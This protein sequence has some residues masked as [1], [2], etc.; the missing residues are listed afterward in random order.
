MLQ[1]CCYR[2]NFDGEIGQ[3]LETPHRAPRATLSQRSTFPKSLFASTATAVQLNHAFTS[4][5]EYCAVVYSNLLL[6]TF[7][8]LGKSLLGGVF[9]GVLSARAVLIKS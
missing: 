2:K 9:S 7:G 8:G 4:F 1:V 6:K 3:K 5:L